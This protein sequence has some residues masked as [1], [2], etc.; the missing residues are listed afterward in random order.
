M[1]TNTAT[2]TGGCA[3]ALTSWRTG[4]NYAAGRVTMACPLVWDDKAH[5]EHDWYSSRSG[6]TVHCYGA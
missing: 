6:R 1:T 5:G 2:C 4:E 3:Q